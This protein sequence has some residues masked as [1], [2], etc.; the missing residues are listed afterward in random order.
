MT[1]KPLTENDIVNTRTLLHEAIPL[2]GTILSGT[3]NSENIKN[4]SHG[5]FQ[6]VYD[7]PYLSSSANH[8]FDI[9]V[10][11]DTNSS[12]YS[13]I[14]T[15]N[16][17]KSKK[18]NIYNQMS[19]VLMGYDAT[20]SILKFD[21]DGDIIGG[22]NK[23][24]EC[25][26]LPFARLLSKDEVKKE[27]FALT[28]GVNNNYDTPFATA[29]VITVSDVSASTEYRVNSPVGEYG[30]L[31]ATASASGQFLNTSSTHTASINGVTYWYAG[32]L[33][34]QAGVAVLT[35]SLFGSQLNEAGSGI[36]GTLQFN[37]VA[38]LHRI[39]SVLTASQISG[40][41]DNFRHRVKNLQFNNTT[42]LNS[43]VYF[44][45]ANHNEFNY[46]SNPTY[47]SNSKIRVKSQATDDPL[48]YITTVG[49][50]NDNNEL[51]ATAKLSEPLKKSPAT[52]F[53]IR[54]RLDY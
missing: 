8:I 19:Q 29:R 43:T 9:T 11:I 5:M 2:T 33:F 53:T 16:G 12:L 31:Y 52:E 21:E 30:I 20:G 23:L 54:T 34:Y 42:E 39:N 17:Q 3:Y 6:S 28:L 24:N 18:K 49:L 32:L 13:L 26:V 46:S 37:N 50:Y 38:G 36:G 44:C 27:S 48:A 51:M 35:A 7:Y 22:G 14:T 15:S 41:A 4:Y 40:A 1:F 47:T 10:G 25:I 45:R